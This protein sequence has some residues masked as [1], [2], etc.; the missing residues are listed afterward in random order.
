MLTIIKGKLG[1][2]SRS[3]M[4]AAMG[5]RPYRKLG[6]RLK[7]KPSLRG[8]PLGKSSVYHHFSQELIICT[9]ITMAK[10]RCYYRA[11]GRPIQPKVSPAALPG[12]ISITCVKEF[13]SKAP[14]PYFTAS[15]TIIDR[16]Y[17]KNATM[18]RPPQQ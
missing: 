1:K 2:E 11:D 18:H 6:C 13:L 9:P 7:I 16:Y 12:P 10:C 3:N 8:A 14:E 4:H 17:V 15:A 5:R